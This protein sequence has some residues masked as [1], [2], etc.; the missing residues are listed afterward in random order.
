VDEPTA[1]NHHENRLGSRER[2]RTLKSYQARPPPAER[3]FPK[4]HRLGVAKPTYTILG[5]LRSMVTS[6]QAVNK[7]FLLAI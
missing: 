1:E 3:V 2:D 4:Y 7:P 5:T 6:R